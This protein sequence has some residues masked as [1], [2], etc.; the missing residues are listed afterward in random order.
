MELLNEE[1]YVEDQELYQQRVEELGF[2]PYGPPKMLSKLIFCC[3]KVKFR[4]AKKNEQTGA[5]SLD[6]FVDWVRKKH[7]LPSPPH[8][9]KGKFDPKYVFEV[10][11]TEKGETE[12]KT[13]A[14]FAL[15][16]HEDGFHN[17]K[18]TPIPRNLSALKALLPIESREFSCQEHGT[19]Y[20][21][22]LYPRQLSSEG[23]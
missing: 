19:S 5:P 11:V 7:T 14:K 8:N 10:A 20:T 3:N 17:Y 2:D 13:F 22:N 12:A 16:V 15:W 1:G 9:P 6:P 18:E 23:Q 21:V 4:T